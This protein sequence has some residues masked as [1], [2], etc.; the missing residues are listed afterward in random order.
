MA[1]LAIT[2]TVQGLTGVRTERPIQACGREGSDQDQTLAMKA[3][4]SK[5]NNRDPQGKEKVSEGTELRKAGVLV[6]CQ[7]DW[8]NF[9]GLGRTSRLA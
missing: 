3:K 6:R 1:N 8:D 9:G 4:R 7:V 5:G 2:R